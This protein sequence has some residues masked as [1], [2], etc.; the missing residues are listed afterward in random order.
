M[1]LELDALR[2]H[3]Q[4]LGRMLFVIGVVSDTITMILRGKQIG[5]ERLK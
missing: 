3:L 4:T 1:L 2:L 5:P